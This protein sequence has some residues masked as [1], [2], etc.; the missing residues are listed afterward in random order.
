M[1]LFARFRQLTI[2]VRFI[3]AAAAAI[4]IFFTDYFRLILF[5]IDITF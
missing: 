3:F 2:F 4:D 1:M 5:S